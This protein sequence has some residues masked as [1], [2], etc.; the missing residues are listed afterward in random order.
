MVAAAHRSGRRGRARPD[1]G[2]WVLV[3]GH[4]QA[5]PHGE[6]IRGGNAGTH[7]DGGLGRASRTASASW[8]SDLSAG[9]G[10]RIGGVALGGALVGEAGEEAEEGAA[11]IG[12]RAAPLCVRD[13]IRLS[14]P[15][16]LE[17]R[18]DLLG[19]LEDRLGDRVRSGDA[20]GVGGADD[21][22]YAAGARAFGHEAVQ[23]DRDDEVLIAEHEP[24]RDRLPRRLAGGQAGGQRRLSDRTLS[25]EHQRGPL[26]WHVGGELV[27]EG[28]FADGELGAAGR[29]RVGGERVAGV[30]PGN[31]VDRSNADSPVS[32]VNAQT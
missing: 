24:G 20:Q 23:R 32:A 28:V 21:F 27:V 18:A 15:A 25:R 12:V 22:A 5:F 3:H 14:S 29:D 31:F 2:V 19:S 7:R 13:K 10:D 4:Q 26:G 17:S 30:L 9:D 11:G 6:E 16:G 8:M 1:R